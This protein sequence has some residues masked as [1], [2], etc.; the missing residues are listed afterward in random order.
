MEHV[1]L[2]GTTKSTTWRD[3]LIERLKARGVDD[4]R[5]INPHLPKGVPYTREDMQREDAYK[6]DPGTLVFIYLC[7]AVVTDPSLDAE[8]ARH[9]AEMLGAL[10]MYEM[11][12]YVHSQPQRTGALLAVNQFTE[13]R[14][15]H[16]VVAGL[17]DRHRRKFDGQPPYLPDWQSAD[18][19]I[20]SRLTGR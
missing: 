9:E 15:P 1:I 18:D 13:G 5:I 17:A 20:V 4:G 12:E 6:E 19:W 11:G 7:P 14:R 16:K 3:D 2:L 10:T 8:A